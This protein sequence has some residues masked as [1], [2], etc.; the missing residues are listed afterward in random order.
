[1][2]DEVVAP[3]G[4]LLGVA[5]EDLVELLAWAQTGEDDVDGALG[6]AGQALGHLVDAHRRAHVE[7]QHLA[8]PPDRPGLDHQ[9]HRLLHRHEVTGDVGVSDG[10]GA[11]AATW[12]WKVPS[13]E[14]RLPSTLPKR[15]LR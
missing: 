12:A 4:A 6:L 7:H 13:M 8:V 15:T 9:L 2:G 5:G 11:P 14:S 1:V 10:D 3:G